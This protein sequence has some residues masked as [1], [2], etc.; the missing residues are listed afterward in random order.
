V[1][2]FLERL[3]DWTSSLIVAIWDEGVRDRAVDSNRF[4]F[5]CSEIFISF[6]YVDHYISQ[7]NLMTSFGLVRRG[8]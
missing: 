2:S 1:S 6:L 3:I 7:T 8:Y 4:H 5:A